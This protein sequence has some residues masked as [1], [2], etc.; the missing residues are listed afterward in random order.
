MEYDTLD[1]PGIAEAGIQWD[2]VQ[3]VVHAWSLAQSTGQWDGDE[4]KYVIVLKDG[5]WAF[6][7]GWCDYT[8]WGCQDGAMAYFASSEEE[9]VENHLS[10][11]DRE[12][13]G[14]P[15]LKA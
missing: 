8:G 10:V 14:Y 4:V 11:G 12:I 6:I 1:H 2:E 13:F 15:P 3:E 5:R 7:E 9:L